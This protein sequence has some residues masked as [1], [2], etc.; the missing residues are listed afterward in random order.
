MLARPPLLILSCY[1]SGS[2]LL[3]YVLDT[4][5]EIYCPPEVS[6]GQ[7]AEALG[8]FHAGFA[9]RRFDAGKAGEQNQEEIARIRGYLSQ[10]M[11]EA[12][13]RR[14]KSWLCEKSPSNVL[15]LPLL[16][17]LF[18]GSR[19]LCLHRHALD[20]VSSTIKM[21]A[22]IPELAPYVYRANGDLVT[23]FLTYWSE[24]TETLLQFERAHP[25]A[26]WRLRYEDLVSEPRQQVGGLFSFLGLDWQPEL[27]EAVFDRP[28]DAGREDPYIRF[29][30]TIHTGSVG[31]GRGLSLAH[32][33]PELRR[34]V[35]SLLREL[36]YPEEAG[37]GVAL[38]AREPAPAEGCDW[39]L[40]V[41]LPRQILAHP[42][43][44]AGIDSAF[45]IVVKGGDDRGWLV[46][47]RAGGAGVVPGGADARCKVHVSASDLLSIA[48]GK[49]NPRKAYEDGRLAI[50]GDFDL[51]TLPSLVRLLYIADE[52][53]IGR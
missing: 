21:H 44:V 32:V 53:E 10:V 28:H 47:L 16:D 17:T 50:E 31:A 3:R 19:F 51:Q 38:P 14:G 52:A 26:C 9:G 41:H 12:L 6:L 13:E 30:S 37:G 25:G 2:T 29:S 11:S 34:R 1:R 7:L 36:G 35:G 49:L 8:H 18:P 43:M 46:D 27:L 15:F 40:G 24:W 22:G 5:P 39:L 33:Q 42:D 4:H 48:R 20:V 23:A 45:N